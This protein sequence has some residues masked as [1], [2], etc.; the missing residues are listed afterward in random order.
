MCLATALSGG[1]AW[2]VAPSYP[3]ASVGWREIESLA[4]QIPGAVIKKDERLIKIGRGSVQAKSADNPQSLRG[5]GLNFL[6]MDEC[7]YIN[8][9]TWTEVL[10]PALSDRKGS[11][12]FISTPAG[13]NWFWERWQAGQGDDP[14]WQSWQ[15]P[16]SDNPFIDPAEIEAARLSMPDRNFRQEYLAEFIADGSGVFTRIR[17]AA[18]ASPVAEADKDHHIVAGIDWSGGGADFTVVTIIDASTKTEI[19]KE[20]FS[21]ADWGMNEARV[22]AVLRRF[23]VHTALGEENGM[24]APLNNNLRRKNVR[25]RDFHTSN[26]SK[27]DLIESLAMAFE[28][29][30]IKIIND[31]TTIGELEAFESTRLPG[32][33]VRY[34]A[35]GSG[36]DDTVMSLALAWKAAQGRSFTFA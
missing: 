2:W 3:I 20:R 30:H 13:R 6:V 18:V 21:G 24:G 33:D 34:A 12:M 4:G 17:E 28:Q 36:H 25:V 5:E 22:E 1:R 10:R 9:V 29:G 23:N 26:A 32:G 19:H 7:A 15:L 16:T 8:E 11:A 27:A 14:E 31:K 35:P